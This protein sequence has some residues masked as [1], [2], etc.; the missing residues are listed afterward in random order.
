MALNVGKIKGTGGKSTPQEALGAG[1]YPARVVQ[2]IDL[3]LQA[4]DPWQGDEK[5]PKNEMLI[6]YE[7]LDEFMINEDGEEQL[8]KPRWLSEDFTLN[9]LESDLAKSTKRYMVLDPEVKDGGDFIAQLGKPC[10]ISVVQNP[11]KGKNVGKTYNNVINIAA[12]RPKDVNKAADLVNKPLSFELEEPDM[13]V[14]NNLPEW[15]QNKIKGNLEY[16][17]SPLQEALGETPAPEEEEGDDK[18]N[19]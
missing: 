9:S 6:T 1:S 18:E 5:P 13:E 19:W 8:D 3:G 10:M 17:G 2:V 7:C 16:N 11:G 14:F 15:I 12:M 4:Q